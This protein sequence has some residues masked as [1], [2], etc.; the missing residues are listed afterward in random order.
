MQSNHAVH[1]ALAIALCALA[2]IGGVGA[3]S[4]NTDV[5]DL[6]WDPS[7]S[8]WGMQLVNTGTLVFATVYVYGQDGKP[9]WLTGSLYRTGA[10]PPTFAG[11]LMVTTGPY[12]GGSFNPAN[13][14]RRLAGRMTFVLTGVST[15]QLAYSVDGV[16]VDKSVQ[17]QPLTLDDYSGF[18]VVS[19]IGTRTGCYDPQGNGLYGT[20]ALVEVTHEGQSMHVL[21]GESDGTV[22]EQTGSY[23]QLGRMGRFDATYTCSSGDSGTAAYSEMNNRVAVFNARLQRYSARTGCRAS[24]LI[25][26]L[27]PEG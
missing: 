12:F 23:S 8:G 6:W 16:L 21:W 11:D 2:T 3:T 25:T 4:S 26:A 7:Q 24:T 27:S 14:T 10:S 20:A 15:G 22:C 17:R 1:F 19:I 5:T 9:T 13:V 18:Y